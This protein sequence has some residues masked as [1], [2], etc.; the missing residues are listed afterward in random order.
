LEDH[1]GD[2]AER[3]HQVGVASLCTT[4]ASSVERRP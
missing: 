1:V 3:E 2:G 4:L